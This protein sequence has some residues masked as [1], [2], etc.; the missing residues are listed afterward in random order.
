[1]FVVSRTDVFA[2]WLDDL[3]DK[4][5][6]HKIM[7]SIKRI[8]VGNLQDH[9]TVGNGVSEIRLSYGPG[10]RLYYTVRGLQ[11]IILLCGG[12]KDSQHKDIKTA[13]ELAK[14]V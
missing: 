8:E 11:I 12:D 5:A 4:S 6:Q 7:V 2:E 10:Y 1:M 13:K 14:E 9:H 3:N